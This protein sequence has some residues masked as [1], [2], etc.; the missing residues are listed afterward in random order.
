VELLV[1]VLFVATTPPLKLMVTPL[2]AA[3][4]E[5]LTVPLITPE[6]A[7]AKFSVVFVP[8]LTVALLLWLSQPLLEVVTVYVPAAR[9]VSV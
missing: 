7:I 9:P 2:T 3:P 4:L 1:T 5:L 8:L 6:V